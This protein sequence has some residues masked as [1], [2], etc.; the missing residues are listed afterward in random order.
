MPPELRPI[1]DQDRQRRRDRRN[2][3]FDLVNRI[4]EF[5]IVNVWLAADAFAVDAH[6][7]AISMIINH[8]LPRFAVLGAAQKQAAVGPEVVV[9]FQSHFEIAELLIGDDNA[10]VA[11]NILGTEHDTV[12]DHPATAGLMFARAAVAGFGA[13]MPAAEGATI[14]N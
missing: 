7:V 9:H 2:D 11:G 8:G 5:E 6:E 1:F 10:A 12:L 13:D 4:E 3:F 14:E